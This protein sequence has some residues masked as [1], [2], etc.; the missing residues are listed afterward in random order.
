M[1][2]GLTAALPALT[3]LAIQVRG[4]VGVAVRLRTARYALTSESGLPCKLLR[5]PGHAPQRSPLRPLTDVQA[6][7]APQQGPAPG[8]AQPANLDDVPLDDI[9]DLPEE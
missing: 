5:L 3:A 2:P 8:H 6:A 4:A 9:L 7:Q 1:L